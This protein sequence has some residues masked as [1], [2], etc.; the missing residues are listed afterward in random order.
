MRPGI[1]THLIGQA[2][3]GN[4]GR[5]W[6]AM[7]AGGSRADKI[8]V[9]TEHPVHTGRQFSPLQ[10]R[11]AAMSGE[12][13]QECLPVVIQSHWILN[14]SGTVKSCLCFMTTFLEPEM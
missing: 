12:V 5:I 7:V 10:S 8:L 1:K 11:T 13:L 6:K 4:G 3:L 14:L 9:L 2:L